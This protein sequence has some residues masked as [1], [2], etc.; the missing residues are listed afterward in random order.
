[1]HSELACRKKPY[2]ASSADCSPSFLKVI[3]T[4]AEGGTVINY[5]SRFSITGMTGTFPATVTTGLESVSGTDGPATDN[6]DT[7][8]AT[9]A[10][11]AAG[12]DFTLA[13]QLQTGLTKYAPMQPV[14]HT[15]ITA[16]SPTPLHPTSAYTIATTYLSAATILTTITESQTYSVSSIE[17]TVSL[18]PPSSV[19]HEIGI[20]I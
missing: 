14:P 17:N 2:H 16:T 20:L 18:V 1:M 3:S 19:S 6:D 11:A 13:Y 8:A 5:S 12:G 9:T 15:K 4:I 7:T 10:A